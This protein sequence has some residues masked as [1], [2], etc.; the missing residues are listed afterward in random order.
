MSGSDLE[1]VC[2]EGRLGLHVSTANVVNLPFPDH[3]HHL[4]ASQSLPCRSQAAEPEP[5]SDQA[6]DPTVTLRL[7]VRLHVKL[8]QVFMHCTQRE[9]LHLTLR[10]AAKA[11]H[12][13]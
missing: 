12:L 9:T 2:N 7:T 10:L 6:F 8:Y 5:G 13:T 11:L 3:R 4:I 1:E